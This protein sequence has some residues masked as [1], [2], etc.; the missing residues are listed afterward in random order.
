M[1]T[2]RACRHPAPKLQEEDI[3]PYLEDIPGWAVE[4]DAL[5]KPFSFADHHQLMAF[6]N[7]VAWVSHRNDHHP[8]VQYAYK[9]CT[10]RYTTHDS[11]GLTE[12]DFICAAKVEL[13]LTL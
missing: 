1:L 6:V 4:G 12:N 5:V 13:L 2:A 8:D 11:G 9:K 10:L 3:K 7:A